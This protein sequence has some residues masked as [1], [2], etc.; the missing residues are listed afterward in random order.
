MNRK[1]YI[2]YII[3]RLYRSY[4]NSTP[5]GRRFLL[6]FSLLGGIFALSALAVIGT[7]LNIFAWFMYSA[8]IGAIVGGIAEMIWRIRQIVRQIEG[9]EK[10]K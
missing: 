3:K 8:A 6:V 7:A 1:Q 10:R 9:S 2:L 5:E 4:P